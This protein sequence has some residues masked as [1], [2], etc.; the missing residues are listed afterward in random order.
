M[1]RYEGCGLFRQRI[2]ASLLSGKTVLI[3]KIR[4]RSVDEGYQCGLQDFEAN[5]LRLIEK[6]CDGCVVEINETGTSLKFK[7]GIL[8][9]GAIKE[10]HNCGVS[11]SIGWFIEGIIP[12]AIFSKS[13][14]SITFSGLTNDCQDISV[15]ILRN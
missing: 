6:L 5:F 7:P 11:R 4:E 3:T 13:N 12:L 1:L 9:G 15:D 14:V 10:P 2:C 8:L